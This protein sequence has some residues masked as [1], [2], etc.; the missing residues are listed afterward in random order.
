MHSL[1]GLHVNVV[2]YVTIDPFP[3]PSL[4]VSSVDVHIHVFLTSALVGSDWSVS[5]LFRFTPWGRVPNT[6]Y[7]GGWVDP[8]AEL[9]GMEK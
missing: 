9:E 2:S 3:R 7:I 5:H 1:P 6:H 8:R 4:L